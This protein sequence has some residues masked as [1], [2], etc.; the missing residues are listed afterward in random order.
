VKKSGSHQ[1][2][3]PS[4]IQVENLYQLEIF[5]ILLR[6]EGDGDIE[7]IQFVLLNK[8]EQQVKRSFKPL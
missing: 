4:D 5:Q 7:D 6:D 1:E 2:V 3:L 8:M